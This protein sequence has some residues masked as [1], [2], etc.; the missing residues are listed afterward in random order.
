M[1]AA[2]TQAREV[3]AAAKTT[4]SVATLIAH[5]FARETTTSR[6]SAALHAKDMEDR[7][8][9]VE[10]E[11]LERVSRAEAENA[12]VLASTHEDAEGLAQKVTFLKDELVAERRA[13]EVSKRECQE[14]FVELTLLQ[15]RGSELCYAIVGSLWTKHHLSEGVWI[16]TLRHTEMVGEHATLR[17]IVTTVVDSVLG[18][19]LSNTFRVEVVSELATKYQKKEDWHSWLERPATRI[20]DLLLGPPPGWARLADHLDEAVR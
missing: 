4:R 1:Q 20:C 2:V 8:S 18:R 19:S 7:A 6:D 10:S 9:L 11:A 5:I 3:T 13:W 16:A 14:L 12:A 15:T 17:A